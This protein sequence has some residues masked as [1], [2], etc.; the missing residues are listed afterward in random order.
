MGVPWLEGTL[1]DLSGTRAAI[2]GVAN[3]ES[4][5]WHVARALEQAGA[6]IHLGY[7]Q[8]FKSRVLQALKGADFAP[9]GLHRCDVTNATE[10][11]EFFKAVG[12]PLHTLVHS[13]GF[14]PYET[15]GKPIHELSSA[16]FA[17]TLEISAFSLLGLTRAALPYLAPEASLIAMTYLGSTRVVPGYKVMGVAKAAL[18]SIVRELAVEIGPRGVRV[19][20]IS[21]GP[22][23]TLAAQVVPD[24]DVML[25]RYAEVA[26]LRAR[27]EASDVADAALF[28][29]SRGARKITG[30]VLFVD[31]GF[32]ILGAAG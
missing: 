5:A 7:Q 16:E 23:R 11:E 27:V 14:A 6:S 8:R 17:Q 13:V 2:F 4:I 21:A 15:F 29:A 12:G 20:A 10:V 1:P 22:I 30:Q 19:N 3:E 32:S 26:P 9:D 18:E 25:K 31:A 28:L 24:F